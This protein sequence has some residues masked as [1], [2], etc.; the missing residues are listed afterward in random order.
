MAV[1]Y[2]LYSKKTK[3][4][5]IGS[6]RENTAE[7]RLI[8]HNDGKVRSTKFGRPWKIILEEKYNTYTEARKRENFLKS[9]VGRQF[10]DNLNL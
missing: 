3:K 4:R 1:V 10:I 5:Y 8:S 2:I 9:G 7:I 6:S